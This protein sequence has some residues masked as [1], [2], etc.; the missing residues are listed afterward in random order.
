MQ[1]H[2]SLLGCDPEVFLFNPESQEFVS[3]VGLIGG[4]K[5]F[6]R[7]INDEGDAVQE[8]NVTVEFNTPPC[9]TVEMF[10]EHINKNKEWIRSRAAELG[11]EVRIV[12]SAKFS[13]AQLS[14]PEAQTFGCEP[15][16]NAWMWGMENP[17]PETEDKSLRSCGGH[18]HIALKDT[19]NHIAV[20][21]AMDLFVGCQMLEFDDDMDR[22]KLYGKPGAFRKKSYGVEYRTASNRWI[23][24]DELIRWVW[25][26][27]EKAVE[28]ARS[29]KGFTQEQGE[30]IQRCINESSLELLAELKAEFQ[31][32]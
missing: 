28:F 31:L 16:F 21:Q 15:D 7:P 18:I 12:P 22:R 13:E 25:D 24:S 29:G 3:S 30:K 2:I 11:L 17:H 27:T 23:E 32:A 4:S 5:D 19:D 26:Q 6:P 1:T 10:I 8:D 20:V 14:T 9:P